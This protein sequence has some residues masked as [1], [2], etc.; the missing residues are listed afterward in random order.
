MLPLGIVDLE[1]ESDNKITVAEFV[2]VRQKSCC[3][4][5]LIQT[6]IDLAILQNKPGLSFFI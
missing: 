5:L 2:V 3:P 4:I 1:I 6:C